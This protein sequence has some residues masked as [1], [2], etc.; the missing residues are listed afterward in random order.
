MSGY[1]KSVPK[2]AKAGAGAP[3]P[4]NGKITIIYADDILSFPERDAGGVKLLGNIVLKAGAKMHYL[5]MTPTSQKLNDEISGDEDMEAFVK[6]AEGIHPGQELDIRE[7]R[8]NA[9]GVG[10]VVIFG[11][12]CGSNTGDVVGD[13]CNPVKL[14][15]SYASDNEGIKNTMM[16]EAV[17]PSSEPIGLY[18]GVITLLANF[19]AAGLALDLTVAN[20]AVQQ[21]PSSAVTAAITAGSID[22]THGTMVS[23]IG[24]GGVDPATLSGATQGVVDVILKDGTVWTALQDAVINLKVVDGGATMYL[25]EQSRA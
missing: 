21:L 2:P 9:L 19:A 14:K 3:S 7:F 11:A 16:F 18:E 5:Y 13:P 12:G 23:L 8:A 4:K 15:G 24:G 25:V 10:F 17:L 1:R 20:G 6:K 22:L